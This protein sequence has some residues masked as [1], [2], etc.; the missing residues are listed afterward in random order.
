MGRETSI[1]VSLL[2]TDAGAT[3]LYHGRYI[4]IQGMDTLS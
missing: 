1:S 4:L 3:D 2:C